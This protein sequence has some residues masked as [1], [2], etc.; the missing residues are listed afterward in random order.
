MINVPPFSSSLLV[1]EVFLSLVTGYCSLHHHK[2]SELPFSI[3]NF[4]IFYDY[5]LLTTRLLYK[6]VRYGRKK[7]H[8][9]KLTETC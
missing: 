4:A 3:S 1:S 5:S 2:Y 7:K 6:K 9:I 8:F